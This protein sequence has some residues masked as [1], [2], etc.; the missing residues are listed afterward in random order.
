MEPIRTALAFL[1]D[2]LEGLDLAWVVSG[3]TALHL[4][5]MRD[6]EPADVD[7]EAG[8]V[9]AQLIGERLST[10]TCLRPV[11]FAETDVLR[12]WFG[13]YEHGGVLIEVIGGLQIAGRSG[14]SAPFAVGDNWGTV[15]ADGMRVPVASLAALSRQYRLLGRADRVA[16][17][18]AHQA[19]GN[20][21]A[22][23][24]IGRQCEEVAGSRPCSQDAAR[25]QGESRR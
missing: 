2:Q 9:G 6:V 4:H 13:K 11:S 24:R 20:P 5:G 7:V 17:I 8:P 22:E 19:A 12:S 10:T 15:D 23:A 14:W 25:R 21:R 1:V 18:D 3:S 16:Q